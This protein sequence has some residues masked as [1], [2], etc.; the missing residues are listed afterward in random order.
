ME[1]EMDLLK[2]YS[3]SATATKDAEPVPPTR[4]WRW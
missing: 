4:V 1:M 2:L 3:T